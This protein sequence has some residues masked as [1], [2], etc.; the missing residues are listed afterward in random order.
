MIPPIDAR[1]VQY[2]IFALIENQITSMFFLTMLFC[3]NVFVIISLN[4][5]KIIRKKN[6]LKNLSLD[7]TYFTS[8]CTLANHKLNFSFLISHLEIKLHFER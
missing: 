6:C 5:Y 2:K 7:L 1:F 3:G 8:L 4:Y